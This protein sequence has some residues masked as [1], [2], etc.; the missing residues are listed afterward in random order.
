[1]SA[2]LLA[3]WLRLQNLGAES[4][5]YDETVSAYL[6]RLDAPSL[7]AH[8]ARDIHPPGYY[9]ILHGWRWLAAPS[10]AHGLEFLYTW[11]SLW[12]GLL[13][14]ALTGVITTWLGDRWAG[15]MALFLAA[16]NPF[17]IMYAQEARMYSLG[18]TCLLLTLAAAMRILAIHA[19]PDLHRDRRLWWAFILYILAALAGLY[20]LYYFLFWLMVLAPLVVLAL[21][22]QSRAKPPKAANGPTLYHARR[23]LAYWLAAQAVVLLGWLPWL[24]I[25]LRQALEPPVPPWRVP[26][27]DSASFIAALL[28][29][30]AAFLVGQSIFGGLRWFWVGLVVVVGAL[31]YYYTKNPH[32][33]YHLQPGASLLPIL[34][35]APPALIYAITLLWTPLYHVRYLAT[36]APVFLILA[37]LLLSLLARRSRLASALLALG[38]ITGSLAGLAAYRHDPTLRADDHRAAVADLAR[39]W[40]PGDVILVNAG[41]VYTALAV[42]WPDTP[43]GPLDAAPPPI[44]AFPRLAAFTAGSRPSAAHTQTDGPW[45]APVVVRSGSVDGSPS[46]GWGDPAADFYAITAAETVDALDGLA[47]T[48]RR[49]WHYRLY[50][51]VSD[52]TGVIR[53]WLAGQGAPFFETT[54]SGPGYLRVEGVM[55]Q[56]LATSPSGQDDV[57]SDNIRFDNIRFDDVRFGEQVALRRHQAA[58][59]IAAGSMLYV[60]LEWAWLPDRPD[61]E[62]AASLRLYGPDAALVSQTDAPLAPTASTTVLALA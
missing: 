7:I 25:F 43:A 9:L 6:A 27:T 16:L 39:R 60:A 45:P 13:V 4:L 8:T 10:L 24:P 26:W 35:L 41:W 23:L 55:A 18:A 57:H 2:L 40:R 33:E 56:G 28:E 52:P 1:M 20:T 15:V 21:V 48:Y 49:I 11:P 51:T 46:L 34:A 32:G 29:G 58:A 22:S 31:Y 59:T 30:V 53:S 62:I 54:Y 5:W 19:R 44:A 38:L 12:F 14:V 17:Q 37:A 42:Y 3:F 61:E 36:Y 50:D 47:A